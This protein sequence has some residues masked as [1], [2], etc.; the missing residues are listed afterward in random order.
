MKTADQKKRA[1]TGSYAI[2]T[3]I[4][5]PALQEVEHD[6]RRKSSPV[7]V[8]R[9]RPRSAWGADTLGAQ[10]LVLIVDDSRQTCRLVARQLESQYRVECAFDGREGL[11]KAKAL[12]PDLIL[13][14][15]IM[16]DV[17]GQEL[18][19]GVRSHPELDAIPIIVMSAMAD[20]EL[21][22]ELLE[23]GAQ[24]YITKP[25]AM[26]ELRARV[27]NLVQ[28]KRIEELL[29]RTAEDQN[30]LAEVGATL[31]TTLDYDETCENVA[32]LCVGR[33]ADF[34]SLEML[35][36]GGEMRRLKVAHR[37]PTQ[38]RLA[39]TLQR[40]QLDLRQ[41]H[42]GSAVVETGQ[43]L[44]VNQV[45]RAYVESISQN[46]EH[47]SALLEL[48]A[49]AILGLPLH[50]HGKLVGAMVLVRTAPN[51]PFT[52][53][54]IELAEEVARRAAL[55]VDN[56][57]LYQRACRAVRMRDDVLGIVAHDLRNPLHG[58]LLHLRMLRRTGQLPERRCQESLKAV[59]SE[60]A[61]L[62]RMIQDLL[63]V[64]RVEAGTFAIQR[65]SLLIG[66]V[67]KDAVEAYRLLAREASIELIL[68]AEPA[69]LELVGDA[70]RI[71]QALGNLIGNAIKFSPA[72]STVRVTVAN[73]DVDCILAVADGGPGIAPDQ[74]P[75][76][77]DRFWQAQKSDHRGAGLGLSIAKS[78][79]EAHG[80]R[81][82]VETRLG[83][84]T[85]FSF[86]L[87]LA[88]AP[89]R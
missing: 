13:T 71:H 17:S 67:A 66:D 7:L 79:V 36:D 48:G 58:M 10:P 69:D 45:A 87:P 75:H 40:V 28:N 54:D 34:C 11:E 3:D 23:Q 55:A 78:I 44:V 42:L 9:Y 83:A 85:T 62:D 50:T 31:A 2:D 53:R 29:Q 37:D 61:R 32:E 73:D 63:D 35:D 56:A 59:L 41:P 82:W 26:A 4:N 6:V 33:L 38:K 47:R 25:F 68:D 76:L 65:R 18:V 12:E 57:R 24:D 8:H 51:D 19:L 70:F 80:G 1:R 86:A 60:A 16:P 15:T 27:A 81:I 88:P 89:P 74:L 46:A 43:R 72:G 30:L 64:V 52:P 20:E 77:F 49:N 84:G 39:A 5:G 22:V 14:D 21:R